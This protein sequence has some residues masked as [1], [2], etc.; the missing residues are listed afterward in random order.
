MSDNEPT[1][2]GEN[3]TTRRGDDTDDLV[4]LDSLGSLQIECYIRSNVSRISERQIES[5][6][7]RLR[8]L[9]KTGLV[10]DYRTA[11]WPPKQHAAVESRASDATRSERFAKFESWADQRGYSLAPAFE[12][13]TVHSSLLDTEDAHE[14]IRVPIVTLALYDDSTETTPLTGVVPYTVNPG[15]DEKRTYTISD[16]LRTLEDRATTT[17]VQQPT[18]AQGEQ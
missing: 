5:L 16:W 10:A 9:E 11:Q 7:E 12:R 13:R 2:L 6:L 1:L 15:T 3:P 17:P 14:E 4:G 8:T 18:T